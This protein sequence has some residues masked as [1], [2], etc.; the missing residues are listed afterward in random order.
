MAITTGVTQVN[1]EPCER[2]D[3]TPWRRDIASLIDGIKR[4]PREDQEAFL[5]QAVLQSDQLPRQIREALYDFRLNGNQS[6]VL[7][8]RGL[9]VDPEL[10]PTPAPGEVVD[11]KTFHSEAAL[12]MVGARLGDLFGYVQMDH[13]DVFQNI[14]P[15]RA[16]EYE[17]SYRGSRVQLE[18]HTEQ[19]FHP[20]SPEYLM[21]FCLRSAPG[22]E[23]FYASMR[24]IRPHLDMCYEQLFEPVYRAG[25]D[26]A[27]GNL[28]TEK[29]NG[30]VMSVLYGNREDPYIRYDLDLMLGVDDRAEAAL[31]AVHQALLA[32]QQ[33]V[34]LQPGDLLLLDNRR[35][36]HGRSVFQARYD[37]RGRWLQR[38]K[39]LRD[40]GRS[41]ADR[42]PGRRM[43]E[44]RFD[45]G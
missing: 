25:V 7:L 21:L 34:E 1:S 36:V 18:Y 24:R 45:L 12:A 41:A 27:F 40:L 20:Y 14:V 31:Q 10:G 38:A 9:P 32:E 11:K 43:I 19:H 37:G 29:G 17:Q 16:N 2:I 4:A 44:T 6:G 28:R 33:S 5:K 15:G 8:F 3:C 35:V 26:Y 13:G 23:T 42:Q 22:A 30:P 39:V